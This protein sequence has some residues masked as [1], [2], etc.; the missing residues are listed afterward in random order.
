M[1]VEEWYALDF[2]ATV[3]QFGKKFDAFLKVTYLPL[4]EN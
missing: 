3:P 4:L 2:V 1:N